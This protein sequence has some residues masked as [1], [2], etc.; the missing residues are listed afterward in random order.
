[1]NILIADDNEDSR[2]ILK[3]TF[4]SQGYTIETATNGKDA[5]KMAKNTPPDVIISD[6]L[7]PVMDG[8]TL[9]QKIRGDDELK[10]ISFVFYTSIYTDEKDEALALKV[11]ADKFIRKPLE[12]DKFIKIIQSAIKNVEKGKARPNKPALEEEEIFKLYSERL[13]KKLEKN[14]QCLKRKMIDQKQTEEALRESEEKYRAMMESM[15]E[16]VFICSPDLRVEYMNKAM[17]KRTGRDAI[18]EPCF[19]ALHDLDEKCPW[20]IHHKVQQGEHLETDIVSPKDNRYYKTSH[21][22]II[23]QDGSVSSIVVFRD[24]TELRKIEARLQQAQ[25]MEAI[26][27]LAGGI[28]HDFNNILFPI[29]GYAE[30]AIND[31]PDGRT[32]KNLKELL[33]SALRAKALVRQILTFSR[34]HNQELKPLDIRLV[35]KEALKLIRSS[36]PTT[37]GIRQNIEEDCGLVIANPTQIHQ[38]VM[39]LCTNAYHAMY[40]TGGILDV[41]LSKVDL[42]VLDLTGLDIEPGRYLCLEVVDTGHGMDQAV[43]DRIFDPYFTTKEKTK[44][45]GLGLAVVHGIVKNYGG[46]IRVYSEPGKGTVFHVYL[47]VIN[48]G[49]VPSEIVSDKPL[50]TGHETILLVD[51]EK[52]IASIEKQMLERLGYHVDVR[53]SSIEALK[54]FRALP[55]KYDLVITDMTMPNMTGDQ[56]AEKIM[57]IRPDIPILLCTG[58]SENISTKRAEALGIKAFLMK[59]IVLKQFADTIRDLLDNG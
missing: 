6:I 48:S 46:D 4:E 32:R 54:A 34:Q 15:M 24:T 19:K 29:I 18:G 56:L 43:I 42:T 30:M 53:T 45:T 58:F 55:D 11:G 47:P 44:G 25:K 8:Y 2:I 5:L 27:T 12:P 50:P 33:K 10:K 52:Q 21:S 39:N 13:V 26:G 31:L 16:P 49:F 57:N 7:M 59:P 38:I 17:I 36:L 14:M 1:M 23:H 35:I 3:K 51:D 9:C 20:C 40:E 22:P 37:I 41:N 28:A